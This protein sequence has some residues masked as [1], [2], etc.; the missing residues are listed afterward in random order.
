VLDQGRTP[1]G[2][3]A[4]GVRST[5]AEQ[6]AEKAGVEKARRVPGP[7]ALILRAFDE[8]R[9]DHHVVAARFEHLY[10]T[11]VEVRIAQIDFVAEDEISAPASFAMKAMP[12]M[13]PH[14]HTLTGRPR[15]HIGSDSIDP[16]GDLMARNARILKSWPQTLFDHHIAVADAAGFHLDPN[17]SRARIRNVSFEDF[18]VSAGLAYLGNCHAFHRSVLSVIFTMIAWV[19]IFVLVFVGRPCLDLTSV[20]RMNFRTE[21]SRI[22]NFLVE[23]GLIV[24]N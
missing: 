6:R 15:A 18:P 4:V 17:F 23:L 16:S 5:E 12:S 21:R 24:F 13:P 22:Q 9:A 3:E 8:L 14:S 10:G 2:L 1:E 7:W 19:A 11:P 20:A